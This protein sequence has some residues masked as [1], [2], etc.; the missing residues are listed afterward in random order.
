MTS[1]CC[2]VS[3]RP[4]SSTSMIHKGLSG[5]YVPP[6]VMNPMS[7][8]S[9]SMAGYNFQPTDDVFLDANIWLFIYG[10]RQAPEK[11]E[12]YSEALYRLLEA[13]SRLFVDVLVLSEVINSCAR[14]RW[15]LDPL[16]REGFKRFRNSSRFAPVAREITDY[17]RR[18]VA[19]CSRIESG[20]QFVDIEGLMSEYQ[21]GGSDFNDQVIRELCKS[22]GFKLLTDD[23]DF[24][25][26]GLTVLTANPRLL[27]GVRRRHRQ[28]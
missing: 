16:K 27:R 12:V 18:I 25:T 7:R 2:V 17:V 14:I 20:F 23:G 22:N 15:Q 11:T 26:Q 6:L 10:P 13:R 5:P 19:H 9:V 8:D 3:S 4:P 24:D 21:V 1:H 28:R